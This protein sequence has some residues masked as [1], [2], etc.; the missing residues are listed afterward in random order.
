MC[1]V[2]KFAA[3]GLVAEISNFG[4]GFRFMGRDSLW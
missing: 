3:C 2:K 1:M 4:R